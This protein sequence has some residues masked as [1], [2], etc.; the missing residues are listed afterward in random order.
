MT[1]T[2]KIIIGGLATT[3][4][5][6]FL[7]GPMG[8]G[9]KC[10]AAA[11]ATAAVSAPAAPVSAVASEAPASAEVVASCQANVD[12]AIAG[13]TVQFV[14]GKAD[15]SPASKELLDAIAAAAK[16][17]AGTTVAIAGHTDRTGD[18]AMNL[19]LSQARAE[20][21][22]TAL[23]ERGVPAERFVATGYGETKPTDAS[24][25]ENNAADR[26]IEFSVSATAAAPASAAPAA[27]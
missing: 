14:T 7:H 5:A 13:K 2:T 9:E 16:D 18:A 8:F 19:S 1:P 10:A 23:S 26:R 4:L 24:A 20:A 17:C 12:K 6:W 3:A 21:V 22:R 27:N 25:P 15:V 11:G